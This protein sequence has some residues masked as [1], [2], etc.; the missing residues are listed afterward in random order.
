MYLGLLIA[1]VSKD[2]ASIPSIK[3]FFNSSFKKPTEIK[4]GMS[5][6]EADDLVSRNEALELQL[7]AELQREKLNRQV[8]ALRKEIVL[9]SNKDGVDEFL[10]HFRRDPQRPI[11]N[12]MEIDE[13]KKSDDLLKN[14]IEKRFAK[15][16][17]EK[18]R[19]FKPDWKRFLPH[20]LIGDYFSRIHERQEDQRIRAGK[21]Y[22]DHLIKKQQGLPIQ[23]YIDQEL[24]K[25]LLQTVL[26]LRLENNYRDAI[27]L[28]NNR[29]K[30]LGDRE[31]AKQQIDQLRK[32]LFDTVII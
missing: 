31:D 7:E 26:K 14:R 25:Y 27:N 32:L 19:G 13:I 17:E 18:K 20:R 1:F 8:E 3:Y 30:Q 15:Y 11:L 23:D 10:T 9:D 21:D 22:A 29:E 5:Y 12:W 16:E 24:H 2:I 28:I 4:Q 6:Q